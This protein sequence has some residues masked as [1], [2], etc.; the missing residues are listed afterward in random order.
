MLVFEWFKIS[1]QKFNI[2]F[3]MFPPINKVTILKGTGFMTC[4]QD[5]AWKKKRNRDWRSLKNEARSMG[6]RCRR[7]SWTNERWMLLLFSLDPKSLQDVGPTHQISSPWLSSS[8]QTA[9][10]MDSHIYVC[11]GVTLCSTAIKIQEISRWINISTLLENIS[12]RCNF[13]KA[14]CKTHVKRITIRRTNTF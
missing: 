9:G 12:A 7:G 5:W 6:E 14:M 3:K 1:T 11:A 13:R 4:P 10:K 8:N 2:T